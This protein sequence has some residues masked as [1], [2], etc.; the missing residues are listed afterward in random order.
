MRIHDRGSVAVEYAL[1][2]GLVSLAIMT[3]VVVF[4][5]MTVDYVAGLRLF[6]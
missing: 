4:G 2:V 6:R 3:V 5:P 1:V